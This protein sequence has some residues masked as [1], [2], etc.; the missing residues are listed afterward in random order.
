MG[1]VED[2]VLQKI[3]RE[4]DDPE[5]NVK[6]KGILNFLVKK[7]QITKAQAAKLLQDLEEVVEVEVGNDEP[8]KLDD[9]VVNVPEEKSYDTDD[10]TNLNPG[11]DDVEEVIEKVVMSPQMTRQDLEDV[12]DEIEEI[13]VNQNVPEVEELVEAETE[14]AVPSYQADPLGA[15]MMGDPLAGG[16]DSAATK[17]PTAPTKTLSSFAGK[18]DNR[19]QWATKWLYI[20]FG[21]LGFLLIM[22][23][24]LYIAVGGQN[25]EK[26]QKVA[27]E[28]F[29]K[30]AYMDAIAKTE[31]LLELSPRHENA[32]SWK[33]RI[34]HCYLAAAW[35]SSN[36]SEVLKL[37]EKHLPDVC[38]EEAFSDLRGDLGIFLPGSA[39]EVTQ[40]AKSVDLSTSTEVLKEYLAIAENASVIVNDSRYLSGSILKQ[41]SVAEQVDEINDNVRRLRDAI[42][43]EEVYALTQDKIK[44]LTADGETDNAFREYNLLLREYSDLG[45]R[46]DLRELMKAVSVKEVEL[47]KDAGISISGKTDDF[48]SLVES[49]VVVARREGNAIGGLKGEVTPVLADGVLYGVDVGD[50]TVLWNRFMGFEASYEPQWADTENHDE[51]IV[52]DQRR[53]QVLKIKA[54]DGSLIWRAE[55]GEEFCQPTVSVG[56]IFVSTFTGKIIGL[57]VVTGNS[58]ASA[59]LPQKKLRVS[60]TA[61]M[62]YPLLYQPGEYSNMYVMSAE[63]LSCREVVYVGHAPGSISAPAYEWS[64]YLLLPVNGADYCDVKVYRQSKDEGVDPGLGLYSTQ[65][66]LRATTG[67]ISTPFFRMGRRVLAVSDTGNLRLFELNKID[68]EDAPLNPVSEQS[69]EVRKGDQNFVQ[70]E[71]SRLWIAGK[72]IERYRLS[73]TNDFKRKTMANPGDFFLGAVTRFDSTLVHVRRRANSAMTSI[74]AVNDDSMKE[75]WRTDLGGAFAGSPKLVNGKVQVVSSQGDMFSLDEAAFRVGYTD[76]GVWSA[77]V[78]ENFQF[79]QTLDLDNGSYVCVG[80]EG[81]RDVLLVRQDGTTVLARLPMEAACP[82]VSI[83]DSILVASGKL[84]QLA[85]VSPETGGKKGNPFQPAKRAG[86]PTRWVTPSVLS[87]SMVIAGREEGVVYLLKTNGRNLE[88]LTEQK[89]AGVLASGFVSQGNVAYAVV[90]NDE[91]NELTAWNTDGGLSEKASVKLESNLVA[92][93]WV[94]GDSLLFTNEQGELVSFSLDLSGKR[95]SLPLN[96]DSLAGE[97]IVSGQSVLL[98]LKS[99]TMKVI[100][101]GSGDVQ[102][103][104]DFGQ[105]VQHSPLFTTDKVFIGGADGRLLVLPRSAF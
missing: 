102:K 42:T 15:A 70:A 22:G 30:R 49:Q 46:E 21:V 80:P 17:D 4:I 79:E 60:P 16:F 61:S 9:I 38:D 75:I 41:P 63:D 35:E 28:S 72:G 76:R 40:V 96:N 39:L 25:I 29:Q 27:E 99:G 57:D 52:S 78:A 32:S 87:D 90:A 10:L 13:V 37:S 51:L 26:L 43:K 82:I 81:K 2:R 7:E 45:T 100:D 85:I 58:F 83:N 11:Q 54:S 69:F 92:G 8:V 73:Q 97:P 20:G 62:R 24:V 50:G 77:D 12:E 105:P 86:V 48:D 6:P 66:V 5:K 18:R 67:H 101:L 23:A 93:P 1:L 34:V 94:V 33:V 95:W 36:Y 53:H 31:K 68:S 91:S 44:Q 89:L 56:K 55:I 88:L 47:V 74:S 59:E 84:G 64:G 19:D 14:P 3:R 65:T 103:E 98:T 104:V 71:G